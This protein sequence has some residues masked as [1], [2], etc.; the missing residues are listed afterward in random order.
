MSGELGSVRLLDWKPLRLSVE[1][2]I[3]A[4][5]ALF[6]RR[7]VE[8]SPVAGS[9]SAWVNL[10]S[11]KHLPKATPPPV[12]VQA[13]APEIACAPPPAKPGSIF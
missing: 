8:V 1:D 9:G 13:P 12:P 7:M 2:R 4:E 5:R 11:L 10:A 6:G 3:V